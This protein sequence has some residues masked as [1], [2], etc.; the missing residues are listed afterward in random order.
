MPPKRKRKT[1][2]EEVPNKK[3][4]IVIRTQQHLTVLEKCIS[5]TIGGIII[6]DLLN[7][8]KSYCDAYI[9]ICGRMTDIPDSKV[10]VGCVAHRYDH[11]FE[12]RHP[13]MASETNWMIHEIRWDLFQKHYDTSDNPQCASVRNDMNCHAAVIKTHLT[14]AEQKQWSLETIGKRMREIPLGKHAMRYTN[15]KRIHGTL[16]RAREKTNP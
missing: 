4:K 11:C 1:E 2:E 7:I 14:P 9:C 15:T 12:C 3:Q 6:P 13:I 5:D 10:C 16:P 8:I